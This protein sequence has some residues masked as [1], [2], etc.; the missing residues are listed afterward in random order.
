MKIRLL[1]INLNKTCLKSYHKKLQERKELAFT[2]MV[3]LQNQ[4]LSDESEDMCKPVRNAEENKKND[5]SRSRGETD[6]RNGS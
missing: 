6:K 2:Y 4:L 3:L 5:V 1:S